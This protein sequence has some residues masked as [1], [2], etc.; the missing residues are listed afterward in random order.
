MREHAASVV[1]RYVPQGGYNG[2]FVST[3]NIQPKTTTRTGEYPNF[4]FP[5]FVF[6]GP[7][8]GGALSLNDVSSD[9]L[10]NFS[11]D[12]YLQQISTIFFS[13]FNSLFF[14]ISDEIKIS[15]LIFGRATSVELDVNQVEKVS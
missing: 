6:V 14:S 15:V 2:A 4:L 1:N 11:Q 3:E 9:A 13:P 5:D 10:S 8:Q 7:L 12:S